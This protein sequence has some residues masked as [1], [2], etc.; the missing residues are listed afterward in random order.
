MTGVTVVALVPV[1]FGLALGYFAGRLGIVDSKGVTGLNTY[2]MRYAMPAALFLAA[3]QMPRQALVLNGKLFLVLALTSLTVFF[4]GL[5]VQVKLYR[6]TPADSAALLLA[7]ASPNFVAV[8]Y[9][10]FL[11]L[12]GPQGTVPVG[13][14]ILCGNLLIV[15]LTLLLLE[16][17]AAAQSS[18]SILRRYM[19]A[20]LKSVSNPIV[21]GPALGLCLTLAGYTLSPVWT[22]SFGVFSES[23]AGVGLF[24]TGLILA[25]ESASF[26][27]NVFSSLLVKLIFQPL[28]AFVIASFFLHF[29]VQV[30]RDAVLLLAGPCG[31]FGIIFAVAF[32]A[33][34]REAESVLLLSTA[35]SALTLP[36]VIPLLS[37]IR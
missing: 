17:G 13:V 35:A 3:A 16:A 15:P 26:G 9:P 25:G 12:Y 11:A 31:F 29:P 8:G 30:V 1:Y 20:V 32:R 5:V 4:I 27:S 18:A 33:R 7:V 2:L 19:T 34:T 6:F 23:V 24:A 28:L 10:L 36:V 14:A 37:W 22:R 21:L